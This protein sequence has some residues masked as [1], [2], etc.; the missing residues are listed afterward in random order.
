MKKIIVLFNTLFA[1]ASLAAQE[2][3]A[4][5]A[6]AEATPTIEKEIEVAPQRVY[7]FAA[8]DRPSLLPKDMFELTLGWKGS[9]DKNFSTGSNFGFDYGLNDRFMVQLRYAGINITPASTEK[10]VD[11]SRRLGLTVQALPF[12]TSNEYIGIGT[13]FKLSVPFY[14][15][16]R[17]DNN[18]IRT[19]SFAM[20]TSLYTPGQHYLVQIFNNN[21][22]NVNVEKGSVEDGKQTVS[23]DLP[24]TLGYQIVPRVWVDATVTL[25][26]IV[27][28]DFSKS[29]AFW[30]AALPV[31]L[32][33]IFTI[34]RWFDITAGLGAE[35]VK[36]P[37]NTYNFN[38]G[39]AIR[40]DLLS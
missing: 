29:K 36:D 3:P 9:Q 31:D 15:E 21:L 19:I 12:G 18:V 32:S 33:A 6:N 37:L 25:G 40:A 10:I 16:D 13:R 23:T 5:A 30:N 17:A 39:I 35:D 20:P 2:T 7:P 24:L 8:E 28:N 4:A 14:F 22:I 26:T 1:L 11:A 34:S 38:A 27:Y